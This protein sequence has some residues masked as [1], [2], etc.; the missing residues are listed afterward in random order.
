MKTTSET[1]RP[2]SEASLRVEALL[3][4]YA[5]LEQNE[6]DELIFLFPQLSLIEQWILTTDNV[7]ALNF[8]EFQRS[9]GKKIKDDSSGIWQNLA[10]RKRRLVLQKLEDHSLR[11]G[12]KHDIHI[13]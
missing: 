2:P 4:N 6:I 3:R 1:I 13:K 9:H 12:K 5:R 10:F 7:I 11:T 8:A